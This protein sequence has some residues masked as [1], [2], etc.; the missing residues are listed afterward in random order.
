MTWKRVCAVGDVEVNAVKI[1]DI[2]GINILIANYGTGFRAIPPVCPH[3][4]EPLVSR[5]SSPIAF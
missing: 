5:Q 4:E 2:D 3:M 1:F